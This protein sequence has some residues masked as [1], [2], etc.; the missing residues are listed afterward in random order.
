MIKAVK[1]GDW[2]RTGGPSGEMRVVAGGIELQEGEYALKMVVQGDGASTPLSTGDGVVLLDTTL[3]P[4][5]E[6]EGV[7]RDVIRLV[8]Q[9]RRDAGLQVSDRIALTLGVPESVR[10]QIT[11]FQHLLTDATLTTSLAWGAGELNADL[12]GEPV[13]IAVAV[14]G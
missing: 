1:S 13:H 5:L 2:Q 9:A 6:A 12:D 10:R 8:Q 3:T 7:T 11:P 14:A 4:E